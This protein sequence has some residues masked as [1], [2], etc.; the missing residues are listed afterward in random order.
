MPKYKKGESGN[1]NGR[2]RGA[3]SAN[4]LMNDALKEYGATGGFD[5]AQRIIEL[6]STQALAGCVQ[7]QSMIL[8]R[9]SPQLKSVL[10]MVLIPSMPQD[11][12]LKSAN[13]IVA[14]ISNGQ[15][16]PDIGKEL[17]SGITSVM[18]ITEKTDY[19][20]RLQSIEATLKEGNLSKLI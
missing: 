10:P 6:V 14:L 16:S 7:S 8:S 5:V 11:D 20:K 12:L 15:L 19:E 2:P 1:K 18:T 9:I 17:L 3:K 13:H 4:T